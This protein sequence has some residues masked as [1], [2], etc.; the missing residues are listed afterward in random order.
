MT[1]TEQA[2][3]GK[4]RQ[5][6]EQPANRRQDT[7][8]AQRIDR[9]GEGYRGERQKQKSKQRPEPAPERAEQVVAAKQPHQEQRDPRERDRQT[10]EKARHA[11]SLVDTRREGTRYLTPP[12]TA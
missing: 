10:S 9:E 6:G 4:Q 12:P 5:G 2:E 8:T 7:A 3:I 1:T 11:P